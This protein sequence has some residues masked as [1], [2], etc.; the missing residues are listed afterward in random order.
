MSG[1]LAMNLWPMWRCE[2]HGLTT[3][4]Q[5]A[6]TFAGHDDGGTIRGTAVAQARSKIP[7]GDWIHKLNLYAPTTPTTTNGEGE[8]ETEK[9]RETVKTHRVSHV[10]WGDHHHNTLAPPYS[11]TTGV[12]RVAFQ[13]DVVKVRKRPFNLF[14]FLLNGLDRVLFFKPTPRRVEFADVFADKGVRN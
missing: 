4:Q 3:Q 14:Q 12:V 2:T 8:T 5:E 1:P 13:R 7:T 6:L 11:K 10:E 9:E